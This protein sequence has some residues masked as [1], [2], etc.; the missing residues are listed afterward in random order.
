[1]NVYQETYPPGTRHKHI[2][3]TYLADSP[4]YISIRC[5]VCAFCAVFEE[6]FL[7]QRTHIYREG[8]PYDASPEAIKAL[9]FGDTV[10]LQMHPTGYFRLKHPAPDVQDC[11]QHLWHGWTVVEKYP[12]LYHWKQP[13][14]NELYDTYKQGVVKC[15]RCHFVGKHELKWPAD[16]YYQWDIRG[17]LLWAWSEEHTWQLLQFI[18][19]V[20]RNPD[21][22][23]GWMYRLPKQVLTAKVRPLIVKLLLASLVQ[24]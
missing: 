22:A 7:F 9:K 21:Q 10:T 24:P 20:N 12:Y 16:A 1:M 17:A 2:Y 6:P 18:G 4:E 5:P 8:F 23:A 15:R 11:P 13:D 19:G 14:E 3:T